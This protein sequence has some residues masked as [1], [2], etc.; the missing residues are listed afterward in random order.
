MKKNNHRKY[1]AIQNKF[2]KD[3]CLSSWEIAVIPG[4]T[5]PNHS[6]CIK[7]ADATIQNSSLQQKDFKIYI[8]ETLAVNSFSKLSLLSYF[9]V[10]LELT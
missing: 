8:K 1:I 5:V 10:D 7:Q 4:A 2:I 9:F 6:A 3:S